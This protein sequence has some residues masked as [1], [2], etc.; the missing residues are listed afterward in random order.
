MLRNSK[1]L[2]CDQLPCDCDIP[3]L[4]G[5]RLKNRDSE[6]RKPTAPCTPEENSTGKKGNDTESAPI[7][8]D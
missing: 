2:P 3:A 1:I 8:S 6:A 7:S 4:Y 5:Q